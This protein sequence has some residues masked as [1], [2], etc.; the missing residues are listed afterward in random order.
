MTGKSGVLAF[1]LGAGLLMTSAPAGAFDG[2]VQILHGLPVAEALSVSRNE[3]GTRVTIVR[4]NPAAP[5]APQATAPTAVIG[6]EKIQVNNL[7]PTGNWFLDR[8]GENLVIVH[9]YTQQSVMVGGGR[10]I[11]CDAREL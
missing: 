3:G 11:R 1:A 7:E 6:G 5:T 4:G 8:S 9:C 2:K 10:K